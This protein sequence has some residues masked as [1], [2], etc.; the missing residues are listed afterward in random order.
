MAVIV[1]ISTAFQYLTGG[2]D[3]IETVPGPV[4]DIIAG[5]ERLYPGFGDKLIEGG[6]IRGYVNIL[7]N[8]E[9]IRYLEGENTSVSDGDEMV[10]I[11]AIAGG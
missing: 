5:L 7:L 4:I 10:I 6:K 3:M 11:P 8:D 9:D 1:R 2:A